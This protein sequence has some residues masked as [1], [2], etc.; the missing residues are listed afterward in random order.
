[1]ESYYF[2]ELMLWFLAPIAIMLVLALIFIFSLKGDMARIF[3]T[4]HKILSIFGIC[5]SNYVCGSVWSFIL[6]FLM[7]E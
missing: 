1:M 4:K 7:C 5:L 6:N 2:V 3:L